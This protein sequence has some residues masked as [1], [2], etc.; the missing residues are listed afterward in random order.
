MAAGLRA[1]SV[2]YPGLAVARPSSVAPAFDPDRAMGR[3]LGTR[4]VAMIFAFTSIAV[5]NT[6]MMVALRRRRE[7]ARLRLVGAGPRQIR[8]VTRWEAGL[9][10][11]IGLGFG[12]VIAAAALLPLSPAL[13]GGFHPSV[14]GRSLAA[15]LGIS[16]GLAFVG[17]TIPIRRAAPAPPVAAA[18]RE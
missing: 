2:R 1:L 9:I 17:L 14:P 10:V 16:A 13:D 4:F 15:I 18:G 8:A 12:L 6:L 11:A 7:L 3:W 5:I